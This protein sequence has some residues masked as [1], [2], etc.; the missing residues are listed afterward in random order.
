MYGGSDVELTHSCPSGSVLGGWDVESCVL[1]PLGE[2]SCFWSIPGATQAVD[3]TD[4]D[5]ENKRYVDLN[6]SLS[7][8][9][10]I[11]EAGVLRVRAT[12]E[13][14]SIAYP[15]KKFVQVAAYSKYWCM[16]TNAGEIECDA[17]GD[18]PRGISE[19]PSGEF[20]AVDVNENFACA[21]RPSGEIVC[22]GAGAP[23]F[24]D[25]VRLD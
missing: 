14:N 1:E 2:V 3:K 15:G 25:K 7:L 17:Y 16:L 6:Q 24:T 4:F 23:S 21:V 22:W 18:L 8:F 13:K 9:A 12:L 5:L 19:I 20:I 11:D 10:A